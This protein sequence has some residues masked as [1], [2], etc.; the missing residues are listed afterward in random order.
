MSRHAHGF[1]LIDVIVG[2]ALLLVLFMALFGVLR[3]SLTL[4]TIAK[5][6][7]AATELA[8]SQIEYLHGISY[9]AIG[10]I[11]GIP[12]GTVAKNATSTVDGVTY[13]IRTYIV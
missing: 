7:A 13:A 9:D 12:A 1:S 8:S 5:A 6:T 10:T 3:T 11:G 4:S 2:I